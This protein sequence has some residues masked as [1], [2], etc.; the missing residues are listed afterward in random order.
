MFNAAVLTNF[1]DTAVTKLKIQCD[2]DDNDN[3]DNDDDVIIHFLNYQ[4]F[5]I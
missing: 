5:K 1:K 4:Y 3:D 2:D